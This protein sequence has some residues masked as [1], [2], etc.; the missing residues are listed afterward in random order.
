MRRHMMPQLRIRKAPCL[1]LA[2]REPPYIQVSHPV[3]LQCA[4]RAAP[5]RAQLADVRPR[6]RILV[7]VHVLRQLRGERIRQAAR[8]AHEAGRPALRID[9]GPLSA[10]GMHATHVIAQQSRRAVAL[11]AG[12]P[13]AGE[14]RGPGRRH[15]CG[16]RSN[17]MRAQRVQQRKRGIAV[18]AGVRREAAVVLAQMAVDVDL[19]VEQ[20]AAEVA[21]E[22]GGGTTEFRATLKRSLRVRLGI[23]RCSGGCNCNGG[24]TLVAELRA[25]RPIGGD[26]LVTELS[27]IRKL[28]PAC[29]AK[30]GG[31][32]VRL[33]DLKRRQQAVELIDCS[34]FRISFAQRPQPI[35]VLGQH[36]NPTGFHCV[37]SVEED[38]VVL[39]IWICCV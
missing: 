35:V 22:G 33:S 16:M 13:I 29:R 36:A 25:I 4:L 9:D 39:I 10:D 28:L 19:F 38:C 5:F 18:A 32:S 12:D 31:Q 14:R 6:R 26:A 20:P 23:T 15:R 21:L 3:R 24:F 37:S 11:R 30:S 17:A 2:A 1:A 7:R 34:R 27:Q 8:F